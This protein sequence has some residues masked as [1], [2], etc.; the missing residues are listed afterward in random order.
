MQRTFLTGIP[1]GWS[2]ISLLPFAKSSR[3]AL[4]LRCHS[5]LNSGSSSSFWCSLLAPGGASYIK[6]SASF[7]LLSLLTKDLFLYKSCS[8]SYCI[9]SSSCFFFSFSVLCSAIHARLMLSLE[10]GWKGFLHM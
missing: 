7:S 6:L 5:N 9:L 2:L 8:F 10:A 1:K 3:G 4:Y